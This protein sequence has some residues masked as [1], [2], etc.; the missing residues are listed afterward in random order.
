MEDLVFTC[1]AVLPIILLM[2]L[3]YFLKRVGLITPELAKGMNKLVFRAFLPVML[4]LNIYN[5]EDFTSISLGY[6]AY[7]VIFV[8]ILFLICAPLLN[9]FMKDGR[10]KGALLQCLF[11]SNFA[12]IG[13]PLATS[14]FGE[15]G[16]VVA[17]ILSA[18][19]I[20]VFNVL[21]VISLSVF[22]SGEKKGIDVK[23]IL[24]GIAK[25]PLLHGILTGLIGLGIKSLLLQLGIDFRLS[26][27]TVIY[28][29][30]TQLSSLATPLA[31]LAL[32][33]QFEFSAISSMKNAIIVGVSVRT[34]IVPFLGVLIAYLMGCFEG[35]HFAT[36]VAVF[37][38]P[39]AVSSVP[40]AQEMDSDVAL[41]GQLVVW[42]TMVSAFTL[43][44]MTLVLKAIGVF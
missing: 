18:F 24:L 7:V 32:G 15:K 6:V 20:P 43:F 39:V 42:T 37:G 21:A 13:I 11:R 5:I 16:A 31:L 40:M 8:I 12:L 33:A 10:Q 17:T 3:G 28:K 9:K 36:F 1:N 34:V 38:T 26:D 27:L 35:A 41:A 4:F 30:L 25:N 22:N 44:I 29:P 14:I 19:I 23:K 2:V